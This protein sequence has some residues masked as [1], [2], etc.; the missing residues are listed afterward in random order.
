[1]LRKAPWE[2]HEVLQNRLYSYDKVWENLDAEIMGVIAE[3]ALE[4]FHRE[5]LH[6]VDTT[7]KTPEE[8]VEEI[9]EVIQRK[10]AKK[11]RAH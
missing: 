9:I 2:L 8:T 1:M 4:D 5:K 6:E 3:E 7:D 11:H 10:N